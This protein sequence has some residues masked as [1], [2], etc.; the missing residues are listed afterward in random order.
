MKETRFYHKALNLSLLD[1]KA[2]KAALNEQIAREPKKARETAGFPWRRV[3]MIA[4]A[5][6]VLTAAMVMAI[7]SAR[8]EVL[9]W[10]GI[11]EPSEYLSTDPDQRTPIEALDNMI[12]TAKPE[13]TAI[14]INKID[15]TDSQALNSEGALK[16]AELLSQ[17]VR[18]TI[19]DTL[20]DGN[21][22]YVT[23]HLGG[24][25]ALPLL[26]DYTGGNATMI[27]VDPHRVYDLYEGGPGEEYLSGKLPLYERPIASLVLVLDDG[28][29]ISQFVQNMS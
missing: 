29:T 18:I 17:D 26:D 22:A 15:R 25:A 9:S 8:A 24:T 7:P 16:V 10:L 27:Q 5:C 12:T 1:G 11:T 20:F 21:T 3:V 6:L 2:V 23:L 4:T 19:G 13:D 28:S 14:K